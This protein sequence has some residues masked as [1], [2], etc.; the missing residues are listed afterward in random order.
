MMISSVRMET[1][2][3]QRADRAETGREREKSSER[4]Q[5]CMSWQLREAEKLQTTCPVL[6]IT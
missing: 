4:A 2:R 1:Q 3:R 6:T 5:Y